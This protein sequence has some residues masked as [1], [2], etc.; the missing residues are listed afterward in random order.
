MPISLSVLTKALLDGCRMPDTSMYGLRQWH[1]KCTYKWN[2]QT[3]LHK[4]MR[5]SVGGGGANGSGEN[6]VMLE[7]S[8]YVVRSIVKCAVS[9]FLI[10]LFVRLFV[11]QICFQQY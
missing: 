3:L 6:S 5:R 1:I 9:C 4:H 7:R 8:L 2:Q 10:R 11:Q